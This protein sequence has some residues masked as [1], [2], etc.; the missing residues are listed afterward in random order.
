MI[1]EPINIETPGIKNTSYGV[2]IL[3]PLGAFITGPIP[4][5]YRIYVT[6]FI[7]KQTVFKRLDGSFFSYKIPLS[8][9]LGSKIVDAI[10]PKPKKH[11][12][13]I[14]M[15][16][17]K[18]ASLLADI[19]IEELEQGKFKIFIYTVESGKVYQ[20]WNGWSMNF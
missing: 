10:L 18:T 9:A 6:A 8:A 13:R 11:T 2:G 16:L 1:Y 19:V 14:T 15:S 20:P 12:E 5:F 17:N 4:P 7:P 3:T